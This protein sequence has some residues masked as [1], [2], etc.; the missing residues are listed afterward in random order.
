T[1]GVTQDSDSDGLHNSMV[2]PYGYSEFIRIAANYQP[3]KRG[4][5]ITIIPG[6]SIFPYS[7]TGF[8]STFLTY[9]LREVPPS[10]KKW[11]ES[12]DQPSDDLFGNTLL[13]IER[14]SS[15]DAAAR[16]RVGGEITVLARD[17]YFYAGT[18]ANLGP[19]PAEYGVVLGAVPFLASR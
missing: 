8:D 15:P 14:D 11:P 6:F 3:P 4:E 17:Y 1:L 5:P 13:A 12:V 7:T 19:F 18:L 16:M 10:V 9:D 2:Y